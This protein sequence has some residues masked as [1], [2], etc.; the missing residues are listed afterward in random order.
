[1]M[2]MSIKKGKTGY[3]YSASCSEN[4]DYSKQFRAGSVS[5]I[6]LQLN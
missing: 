2:Q 4:D 6:F 3:R 1:M 5:K